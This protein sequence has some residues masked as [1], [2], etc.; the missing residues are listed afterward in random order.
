MGV[1]PGSEDKHGC[2]EPPPDTFTSAGVDARFAQS[3][4][5]KVVTGDV[6]VKI[7][8]SVVSLASNAARSAHLRDY[9]RCLAINRD[10]FNTAQAIYLDNTN[11]FLETKPTPEAF[12]QWQQMYRFPTHSDEQV[13][14]LEREVDKLRE[15]VAKDNKELRA[16]QEHVKDRRLT[17]SQWNSIV[18]ALSKGEKGEIEIAFVSGNS[19]SERYAYDIGLALQES[20]WKVSNMVSAVFLG[21]TPVGLLVVM[22][23]PKVPNVQTL[24]SALLQIDP[25]IQ[26]KINPNLDRPVKLD[27]GSKP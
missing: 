22:K 12:M 11:A 8:P 27:V 3:T 21:G 15:Q 9:L 4:F 25:K 14:V 5:S 26:L 19:E 20:G 18:T 2:K 10:K 6:D 24:L 17:A 1:H 13:K 23:D 7:H 16:V